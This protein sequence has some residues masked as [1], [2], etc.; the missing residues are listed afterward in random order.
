MNITHQ[1]GN[2]VKT[3]LKKKKLLSKSASLELS[4]FGLGKRKMKVVKLI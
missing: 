4:T 1:L 3:Y 2:I